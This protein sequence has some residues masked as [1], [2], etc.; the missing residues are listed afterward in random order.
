MG[1]ER[2]KILLGNIYNGN[3]CGWRDTLYFTILR[4]FDII[5]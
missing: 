5:F 4:N 3:F 1:E 2:V